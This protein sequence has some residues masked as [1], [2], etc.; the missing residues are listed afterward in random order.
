MT[1]RPPAM[2]SAERLLTTLGGGIPDRVPYFLPVTMHGALEVGVP[3]DEYYRSGALVAEGQLRLRA[4]YRDDVLYPFFYGA[5]EVAAFGGEVEFFADGPPNAVGPLLTDPA[6]IR[7]LVAPDVRHSDVL[8]APLEALRITSDAVAGEAL[9]VGVIMSPFSMPV[10][11]VGFAEYLALLYEQPDLARQLLAINADF[12]IEWANAQLAAGA[13]AI[14]Y[15]DPVASPTVLPADMFATFG[16]PLLRQ[17]LA[18]IAGPCAGLLASG[19]S[20]PLVDDLAD[21]AAVIVEVSSDEDVA[22]VKAAAGGRLTVMGNLNGIEMRRW[23]PT[24]A[25]AITRD[26]IREAAPGGGFILSD[27]H[28]EIPLQVPEDVLLAISDA[29]AEF[30]HYPIDA[31]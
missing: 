16:R 5:L 15:F 9:T 8:R 26:L 19:L 2:T 7:D 25:H 20:M 23:T 17:C 14:G 13:D 29:V 21:A 31:G 11:Q 3:L 12:A 4:K 30:G 6:Q 10:M 18:A 28:G 24:E 1:S 27:T 22:E